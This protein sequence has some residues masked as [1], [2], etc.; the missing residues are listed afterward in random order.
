MIDVRARNSATNPVAEVLERRVRLV[1]R[2]VGTIPLAVDHRNNFGVIQPQEL[3][4]F[5]L[6]TAVHE[7][8]AAEGENQ[9]L[10]ILRWHPRSRH[11]GQKRL[12]RAYVIDAFDQQDPR[13]CRVGSSPSSKV[14]EQ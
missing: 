2:I 7:R 14:T 8:V 6:A 11:L 1:R 13:Y 9:K 12:E 4:K 5:G 3:P 10:L